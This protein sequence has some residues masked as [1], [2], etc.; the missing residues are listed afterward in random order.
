MEADLQKG[1]DIRGTDGGS[2]TVGLPPSQIDVWLSAPSHIYFI[3]S[4]GR[5]K[6]GY[7]TN[8]RSR[9]D[10]VCRGCSHPA[11]LILVIPGDR[12]WERGCH[13]LFAA[14]REGGEWFRCEGKVREFLQLYA[15]REGREILELAESP[16]PASQGEAA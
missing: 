12:Q 11:E 5:V 7:S 6:I 15:S 4:A 3:Y 2:I 10:Q 9:V 16:L 14:Y 8:W 1:A 13:N